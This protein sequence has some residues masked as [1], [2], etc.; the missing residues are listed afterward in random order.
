MNFKLE[1]HLDRKI[2]QPLRVP[3]AVFLHKLRIH[4]IFITLVNIINTGT[5]F[6]LIINGYLIFN[7]LLIYV[8]YVL[9]EVDG[10]MARKFNQTTLV[11]KYLDEHNDDAVVILIPAT[12]FFVIFST[13][14][15][16]H[17]NLILIILAILIFIVFIIE[18]LRFVQMDRMAL[19]ILRDSSLILIFK[20]KDFI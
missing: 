14:D 2:A 6:Y 4:P 20:T 1:W 3:V 8:Y 13:M 5:R 17:Y 9:D 7:I 12:S 10:T 11:G 15:I 18:Q 16:Y 19:H